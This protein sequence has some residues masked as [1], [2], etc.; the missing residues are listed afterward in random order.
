MQKF[1]DFLV[2]SISIHGAREKVQIAYFY[3]AE[4]QQ[5][6]RVITEISKEKIVA[7]E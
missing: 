7:K 1:A 4:N 6:R 5:M 2:G 3:V